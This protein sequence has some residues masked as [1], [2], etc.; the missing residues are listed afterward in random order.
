MSGVRLRLE[1]LPPALRALALNQIG[2][3]PPPGPASRPE[4]AK[5]S[6]TGIRALNKTEHRFARDWPP[7][8]AGLILPQALTLPFGDGTCYRPDF[9]LVSDT[10]LTAY[11]VKGGHV[12]KVA[13]SRHGI[14]RFRRAREA[15]PA[16]RFE[17]WT[18]KDQQWSRTL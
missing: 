10:G 14:E 8:T 17:L 12:G 18:W 16:I 1:D 5:P 4:P 9:I 13:W 7:G 6:R 2:A 3:A 11:E 15:F